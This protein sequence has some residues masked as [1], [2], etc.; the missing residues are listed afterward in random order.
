[1][2]SSKTNQQTAKQTPQYSVFDPTA[3]RLLSSAPLLC[4]D[5]K[6]DI[7]P[8]ELSELT[9]KN[10]KFA[11]KTSNGKSIILATTLSPTLGDCVQNVEG[12]PYEWFQI[13][14]AFDEP[15]RIDGKPVVF[16]RAQC[17][18]KNRLK[19][20]FHRAGV[21]FYLAPSGELLVPM[22]SSKKDSFKLTADN[23]VGEHNYIGES[24][25]L[26]TARGFRRELGVSIEPTRLLPML[27]LVIRD[28]EQWQMSAF[29]VYFGVT[30]KLV[31]SEDEIDKEKTKW[32]PLKQLTGK[33]INEIQRELNFRKDS[34]LPL[35]RLISGFEQF[36]SLARE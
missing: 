18:G 14:N 16:Y 23:S 3:R 9:G 20:I 13:F 30:R 34:L 11:Q 29:F 12:T 27:K 2:H 26:A 7:T 33:S 28:E 22:R 8:R 25:L 35:E 17:H 6:R 1:M 4:P 24:Y 32:I 10:L 31:L 5:F 21:A 36:K 19:N 15:Y